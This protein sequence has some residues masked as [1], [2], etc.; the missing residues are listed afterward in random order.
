MRALSYLAPLLILP[1]STALAA[2]PD[3]RFTESTI[4]TAGISEATGMARAPDGS[5]RIFIISKG[6]AVRVFESGAIQA[7]NFANISP[8]YTGSECGLIGIAFD[9]DYTSNR[10][11]YFFVTVSSSEQQIIRYTDQNNI[12]VDKTVIVPGLPTVGANHDGGGIG[13]G[14]DGYLYWAVGDNG[15][16]RGVNNDLS[17]LASKVGRAHADGT[18]PLDNPFYDGAGGNNDYIWARGF[19]NPFTLTFEPG[20][21]RLWVNTVG[22]SWEQVFVVRGGDHA[23][24]SSYENSQPANYI[25]PVIAYRTNSTQSRV[26]GQTG[27]VRTNGALA[28]TTNQAHGFHKG[29][30]I[31]IS[32]AQDSSFN[33]DVFVRDVPSTTEFTAEQAG[34]DAS[35]GGGEATTQELGGCISGGT[36]YDGTD[37]PAEFSGNFLF[38]DYNSDFL[39]RATLDAN[40]EIT[41]VDT[42]GTRMSSIIDLETGPDGSLYILTHGGQLRRAAFNHSAQAIVVSGTRFRLTEGGRLGFS[43]RLAMEPA[44]NVTVTVLNNGADPDVRVDSG[45]TLTFTPANW[46]VPQAVVLLGALDFD[47]TDDQTTLAV[48]SAGLT[49]VSVDVSVRDLNAQSIIVDATTVEV[50]E[51]QSGMF[52]VSLSDIPDLPIQVTASSTSTQIFIA[53][54]EM[55]TFTENNYSAPQQVVFATFEDADANNETA[56]I[57]ISSLEA[58]PRVVHIRIRD[59]DT[60]SPSFTSTPPATGTAGARYEYDAEA[61]GLPAPMFFLDDSP[62]GVIF[63]PVTGVMSFLPFSAGTYNFR[64]IASNGVPPDA[65]QSWSVEVVADAAPSAM[66]VKPLEGDTLSGAANDWYGNG[67]DD[68]GIVRAEFSIDG[69][70]AYAETSTLGRYNYN[71]GANRFDTTALSNGPHALRLT[72]VDT[73]GQRASAEVNIVVR[74]A[75]ASNDAGIPGGGGNNEE[76]GEGGCS[77]TAERS[78]ARAGGSSFALFALAALFIGRVA[79]RSRR[80][81]KTARAR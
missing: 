6:G 4:L 81:A 60:S 67:S 51:G 65:V 3:T 75:V 78:P 39:I 69:T 26:I 8:I 28:V 40:G 61:S 62:S 2:I 72:L 44:N 42:M 27:L 59:N 71:G 5:N 33:G 41:R 79:Q 48:E 56:D 30:K 36:F 63:D 23:G 14:P 9:P 57:V 74:N 45:A 47:T 11:V 24:W 64:V 10:Y 17:S 43:V 19:R 66:I 16:G 15:S 35:S 22:T 7:T 54:G 49:P 52:G 29:E 46:D 68:V 12:G 53:G 13:F 32:G 34:Q 37:F 70:L 80:N 73:A 58:A 50:I 77:C 25:E 18:I 76:N 31:T 1:A 55:L 38:G 20:R 21:G